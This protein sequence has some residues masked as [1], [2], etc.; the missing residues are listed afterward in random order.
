MQS[1]I[2][3]TAKTRFGLVFLSAPRRFASAPI[4]TGRTADPAIHSGDPKG[5]D[6]EEATKAAEAEN[7]TGHKSTKENDPFTPPKTPYASSPNLKNTIVTP[8][9]EPETQQKRY[10]TPNID[11]INCA[12]LDGTPWPEE[13]DLDWHKQR[14]EQEK[15]D[16]EYF[17]HHKASPL[18]M[19]EV[20]DT[21]K[22]ISRASDGY[23]RGGEGLVV[24]LPEQLLSAEETLLRAADMWRERA[25]MGDPDSPQSRVL[26][27]LRGGDL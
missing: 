26:R 2:A 10:T 24:W 7:Q 4:P 17:L 1:R 21:R 22:P 14:E 8:P 13:N 23:F 18:S 9:V 27:E 3:S 16:R 6:A 12:G 11:D 20:A 5:I 19:I 25:M 15:D